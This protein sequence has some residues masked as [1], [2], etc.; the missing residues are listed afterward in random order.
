[1][2]AALADALAHK[3]FRCGTDF[4][5][6][7]QRAIF[8]FR[9]PSELYDYF[10]NSRSG[11]RAQYW[12][13]PE[14]GQVANAECLQ[15]TWPAMLTTLPDRFE[16]REIKTENHWTGRKE[17]DVGGREVL[18]SFFGESFTHPA[19]KIWICERLRHSQYPSLDLRHGAFA[20]RQ[21]GL[22]ERGEATG[23]CFIVMQFGQVVGLLG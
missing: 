18:R 16:A 23:I 3:Y 7:H 11:Y 9:V 10:F 21:V 1:V 20:R 19:A 22:E 15:A 8:Q 2:R 4:Y 6:G 17:I 12:I 13:A 5:R 14:Q